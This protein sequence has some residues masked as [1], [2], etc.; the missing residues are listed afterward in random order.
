MDGLGDP[1]VGIHPAI[2]WT[3]ISLCWSI[4]DRLD[5]RIYYIFLL[6]DWRQLNG[7]ANV[8]LESYYKFQNPRA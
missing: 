6:S 7:K 4:L 2:P 3:C 1:S 8:V 5:P